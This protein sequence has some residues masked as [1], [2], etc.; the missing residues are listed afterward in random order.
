M[1]NISVIIPAHNE[2][3]RIGRAIQSVLNQTR[4]VNE[5]IVVDDGSEDET[6]RIASGFSD[7]VIC[8]RQNNRGAAAARNTGIQHARYEWIAFLDADDE[9]LP[10]HMSNLLTIIQ[11]HP[12]LV[13]S[14]AA[15]EQRNEEGG[16]L[17]R[18]KVDKS[19]VYGD[20]VENYFMAEAK[21][22]FSF[23]TCMLIMKRVFDEVGLFSEEIQQYGEDLDMWCRIA[24]RY[25]RIGYANSIGAVYRRRKGSLTGAG[26]PNISRFLR[27]IKI[28][29]SSAEKM[30]EAVIEKSEVL[31]RAWV[32][33]A[34]K[35][36]IRLKDRESLGEIRKIYYG[37][38]PVHWQIAA[39]VF[40]FPFAM[41]LAELMNRF[42][43]RWRKP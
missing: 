23:T 18:V 37:L 8:I 26:E 15:L 40:R 6:S 19:C 1:F 20:V 4:K 41:K 38:L 33:S 27:R 31:F 34:A 21:K 12:E 16:L 29:R 10:D 13:W 5:I 25:P 35:A 17:D 14:C 32:V 30:P 2:S 39:Q 36:A 22:H 43:F 28:T 42:R 7:L 3:T 9:W 24:L 11:R